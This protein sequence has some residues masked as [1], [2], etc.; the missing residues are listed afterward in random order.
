MVGQQ[1]NSPTKKL[2]VTLLQRV[3]FLNHVVFALFEA[4][5][6]NYNQK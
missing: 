2:M 6:N 5:C 3:S 1:V 4:R